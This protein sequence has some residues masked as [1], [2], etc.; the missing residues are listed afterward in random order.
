MYIRFEGLVADEEDAAEE[1]QV[2]WSSSRDGVL[3]TSPPDATGY[4]AFA[5]NQL[6]LG[7]HQITLTVED[8]FRATGSDSVS[9]TVTIHCGETGYLLGDAGASWDDGFETGELTRWDFANYK[10]VGAGTYGYVMS[11]CDNITDFG[12]EPEAARS[13]ELGLNLTLT[14]DYMS[15]AKRF[16]PSVDM[17]SVYA[18][19][20]V[21]LPGNVGIQFGLFVEGEGD[22]DPNDY[23]L[24]HSG[25]AIL[26]TAPQAYS[27]V[28][29]LPGDQTG[30]SGTS[31]R[32][33]EPDTWMR[34]S[35]FRDLDSGALSFFLEDAELAT[36]IVDDT[37][38]PSGFSI[39]AN[40]Q[41]VVG[42]VTLQVDDCMYYITER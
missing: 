26:L 35:L 20:L 15:V 38:T 29:P 33:V 27:Y 30:F 7:F 5:S 17:A 8:S 32:P 37:R 31:S 9:F 16:S 1:L 12:I 4:V 10:F 3:D 28:P 2:T 14:S 23:E 21:R 19:C 18:E 42:G 25:G 6:S 11:G 22:L 34:L 13:G 39:G 24:H 40:S 36:V 41:G